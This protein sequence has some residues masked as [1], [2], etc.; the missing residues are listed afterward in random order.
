MNIEITQLK[1]EL[2]ELDKIMDEYDRHGMNASNSLEIRA[3]IAD[4]ELEW[5]DRIEENDYKFFVVSDEEFR[6]E[7][8]RNNAR[9]YVAILNRIDYWYDDL[10]TLILS[11]IKSYRNFLYWE[12]VI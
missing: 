11:A 7:K 3:L 6:N 2:E 10:P 12:R 9:S 1:I 4:Y 8:R 5:K